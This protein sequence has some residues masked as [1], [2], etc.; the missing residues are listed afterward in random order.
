MGK[1]VLDFYCPQVKLAV[2]LDG[3]QHG[4]PDNA[5]RDRVRDAWLASRG[6]TVLRVWNGEVMGNLEGVWETMKHEALRLAAADGIRFTSP[7]KGEVGAPRR[8]GVGA[9][10]A[11]PAISRSG[12]SARSTP[13][14][15]LPLSGGGEG[16]FGREEKGS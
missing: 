1:Y 9:A 16:G 13:T 12:T 10:A 5:I 4:E 8:E 3:S 14:P 7:G 6:V 2:E 15:A 11:G